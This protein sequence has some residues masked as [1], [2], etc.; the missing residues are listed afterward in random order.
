MNKYPYQ[1]SSLDIPSRRM[2]RRHMFL[3]NQARLLIYPILILSIGLLAASVTAYADTD[4]GDKVTTNRTEL[5]QHDISQ[6]EDPGDYVVTRS[7][8]DLAMAQMSTSMQK[9]W[10]SMDQ[11]M[12]R[13]RVEFKSEINTLR[14]EVKGDISEL[15]T[16]LKGEIGE[17]RTELKGEIGELRTELKGD[18]SE[19]RSEI[20]EIKS[21]VGELKGAVKGIQ[22]GLFIGSLIIGGLQIYTI[23]RKNVPRPVPRQP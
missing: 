11:Q 2:L 23:R 15:R 17:L 16:E 5:T 19:L 13:L 14:T 18:I 9:E 7:D 12:S 3:S 10:R 21:D 22:L 6:A 20:G 8:L 4:G 1:Q